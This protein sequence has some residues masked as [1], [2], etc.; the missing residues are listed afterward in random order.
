MEEVRLALMGFGNVGRALAQMIIDQRAAVYSRYGKRL[1]VTAIATGSH[2]NLYNPKGIDLKQALQHYAAGGFTEDDDADWTED[3]ADTLMYCGEYDVLVELSPLNIQTGQPAANRIKQALKMKKSAVSANK[4]PLAWY[5][6]DLV[7][8][9]QARGGRFCFESTVMDGTPIFNLKQHCLPLCEVTEIEG[10]LNSTTNFI[11][12]A[13]EEGKTYEQAL[14]EGRAA[15]FVEADPSMDID[16]WDAAAKICVLSNVLMNA[17]IDPGKV[18]VQ[19]ISGITKEQIDAAKARGKRIKLMCRAKK[20]EFGRVTAAVVPEEIDAGSLYASVSG[21]SSVV[22]IVTD[23]MGRLTI[24]E[25]DP[26]I[27]QTA[28]GVFQD[29]LRTF[30]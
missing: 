18:L 30:S 14:E 5:Y 28:Y 3:S 23:L 25:E 9:A 1:L 26:T 7:S 10:I 8:M 16:G 13:L 24:V 15:G 22:S 2:G 4:G 20:D 6:D 11:L 12:R 21:A 27:L 29:I 19:G 17:R